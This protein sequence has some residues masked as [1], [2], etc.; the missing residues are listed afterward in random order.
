MHVNTTLYNRMPMLDYIMQC[1]LTL[2]PYVEDPAIVIRYAIVKS[3]SYIYA[4]IIVVEL[5]I[6]KD[7]KSD[8][9]GLPLRRP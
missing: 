1:S 6:K 5:Q 3:A 2:N 8:T 4:T 7:I 9:K